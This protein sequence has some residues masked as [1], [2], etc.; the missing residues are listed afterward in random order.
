MSMVNLTLLIAPEFHADVALTRNS[1]Y[2]IRRQTFFKE[3]RMRKM[4][5]D[6][7]C[8][9]PGDVVYADHAIGRFDLHGADPEAHKAS[10]YRLAELEV[11]MPLPGHDSVMEKVSA[12]YIGDTVKQWE[13]YIR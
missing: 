2:A 10:L 1:C 11:D 9:I 8:L 12:G 6:G 13:P 3:E 7:V 5:V 4:P